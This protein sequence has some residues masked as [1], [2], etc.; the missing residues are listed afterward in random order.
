MKLNRKHTRERFAFFAVSSIIMLTITVLGPLLKSTTLFNLVINIINS[1]FNINIPTNETGL[2]EYILSII[3]VIII[4]KFILS[5]YK[6][7]EGDIKSV[8]QQRNEPSKIQQDFLLQLYDF[9]YQEKKIDIYK[10]DENGINDSMMHRIDQKINPWYVELSELLTLRSKQYKI[11]LDTDYHAEQKTFISSYGQNNKYAAVLCLKKPPTKPQIQKF[12][13]FIKS[14]NKEYEKIIIGTEI[15][16]VINITEKLNEYEIISKS[17]LIDELVDFSNYYNFIDEQYNKSNFFTP[18]GIKLADTYVAASG[19]NNKNEKIDSVENKL[20]DWSKEESNRHIAVLGEYGQGKSVLSLKFCYEIINNSRFDRIPILIE[21]RG[22]SPRNLSMLEL[23][24][25]WSSKFGLDSNAIFKL[26]KLGKLVLI[27]EGFDEMDL[28]G[29]WSMRASH[30]SSLWEF[31]GFPKSKII[32]TGRPNF[33]LDDNEQNIALGSNEISTS[34]PYCEPIYLESFSQEKII[35]ALRNVNETTKKGIIELTNDS[36]NK[37]FIDLVTRPSTLFLVASIWDKEFINLK[38]KE[39]NSAL[40]I[41]KFI[42]ATNE[43]QIS[44]K[45]NTPLLVNE[46]DFFMIGIAV[47]MAKNNNYSN[48][49]YK[50]DLNKII[51]DLYKIFPD[52]LSEM[53]TI[54]EKPRRPLHKRI[55]GNET[56]ALESILTDI[57]TCG[58]LVKDVSRN[59]YFKFAHKSFFEYLVS[60]YV[61]TDSYSEEQ[62]EKLKTNTIKKALEINGNFKRS[63][64]VNKFVAQLINYS[65]LNNKKYEELDPQFRNI[66][67]SKLM[68]EIFVGKPK[69]I[70]RFLTFIESNIILSTITLFILF[71]VTSYFYIITRNDLPKLLTIFFPLLLGFSTSLLTR[72]FK[73]I[74]KGNSTLKG[75]LSLWLLTCKEAKI[76][77]QILKP[78][79][80]SKYWSQIDENK[81]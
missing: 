31:A 26:Q 23:L 14:Q 77:R 24:A 45:I 54:F 8:R 32:I 5:I 52:K 18:N 40:V 10:P 80:Y 71:I 61:Y 22:K 65:L 46:R 17:K 34:I 73:Y 53:N 70:V 67:I 76:D 51:L 68:F 29:D 1:I 79:V 6:N 56:G 41:Q 49:I 75:K 16:S 50:D 64:E 57:R 28:V 30:F 15:E 13:K 33:F 39:V 60:F 12:L 44:K 2:T 48:Q 4:S 35:K 25:T 81:I 21:L 69:I 9:L 74:K 7:W 20:L 62:N 59:N 63:L 42:K 55:K 43:R 37:S 66:E 38:N 27:F 11:N 58:I 19:R 3:I 72:Y 47:G 78:F 36:Q